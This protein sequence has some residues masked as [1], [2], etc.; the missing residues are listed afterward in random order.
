MKKFYTYHP[1]PSLCVQAP[2]TA[3]TLRAMA[4]T[5]R[6]GA[7]SAHAPPP[8]PSAE[9]FQMSDDGGGTPNHEVMPPQT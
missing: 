7:S 2:S 9:N 5:S 6:A 4:T 1:T 8:R 3:R